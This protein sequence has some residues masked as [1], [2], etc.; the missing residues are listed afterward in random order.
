MQLPRVVIAAVFFVIAAL[1]AVPALWKATS[2]DSRASTSATPSASPT[3][4]GSSASPSPSTSKGKQSKSPKPSTSTKPPTSTRPLSADIGAVSCPGREAKVTIRNTGAQRE[5]YSIEKNDDTAAIPGQIAANSSRT[6]T[7]T[8]REDRRTRVTVTWENKPIETRTLRADC[9]KSGAAPPAT[10]P[11]KLPHT[12][13]DN[14]VLWARAATG[15]AFLLTGLIIFWYGGIW[16]R[17]RE[18]IFTKKAD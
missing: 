8:L 3:P 2:S 5:D 18:Q 1:I 12:G 16:P 14:D 13:P 17:R 6:V 10:P 11:N 4:S 7:V 9:K 15:G